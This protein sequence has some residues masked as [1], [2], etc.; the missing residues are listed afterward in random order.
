MDTLFSGVNP[1]TASADGTITKLSL[2]W[3]PNADSLFYATFSEGFR[4][5]LLN[6]PGGASNPS[7]TFTVPFAVDTDEL[8][9][10]ELGW[11]LDL[12][13]SNLR[14]NGAVF[15]SDIE[16]LQ[17][18]IFDASITNL[19][20]TDNAADAEVKGV[21][22][23]ILWM[24]DSVD[25]LTVSGSF[26][27]ND[28]EITKVITPTNDVTK[29]DSLAFAPEFQFSLRAR[30]E[31]SI[32]SGRVAHFMPHAT[33]SDAS[34]SDIITINR[35]KMDDWLMLGF[36]AGVTV[37]NWSAEFFAEN[38][39]DETAEISRS[40]IYDRHRS[41]YARPFTGGMRLTYDF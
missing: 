25:G 3:T 11:K 19:F 29:G 35:A 5:G 37:D 23:D 36:T 21:E 17:T 27:F 6:R 13:D 28:S 31:W 40:F 30:Y 32:G 18:G 8:T 16:D 38:I 12:L 1:D 26:A 22:G 34:Y 2:S 10:Y 20:F 41:Y 9:N 14:F 24:P 7:G 33:Y 4:P 15:F 39:T